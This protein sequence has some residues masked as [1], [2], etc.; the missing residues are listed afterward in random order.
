MGKTKTKTWEIKMPLWFRRPWEGKLQ[1]ELVLHS[2]CSGGYDPCRLWR[3]LSCRAGWCSFLLW[4]LRP[5]L[6]CTGVIALLRFGLT[7]LTGEREFP[8]QIWVNAAVTLSRS[9]WFG[10]PSLANPVGQ[11]PFQPGQGVLWVKV[12]KSCYTQ[13]HLGGFGQRTEF[14][15]PRSTSP[16]IWQKCQ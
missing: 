3:L 7:P 14:G 11:E 8:G 5:V 9:T 2:Q 12:R 16:R 1:S 15:E 13:G 6:G 4:P 10:E